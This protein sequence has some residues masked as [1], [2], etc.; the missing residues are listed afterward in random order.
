M[1]NLLQ[2][3]MIGREF[4]DTVQSRSPPPAL[5]KVMFAMLAPLA[6]TLGHRGT[7]PQLSRSLVRPRSPTAD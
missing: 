2:L 6:Y 5:Q 1:P 4:A 3:A 7:Y